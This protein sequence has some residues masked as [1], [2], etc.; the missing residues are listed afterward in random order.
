MAYHQSMARAGTEPTTK[1]Y[2]RILV[3]SPGGRIC[4]ENPY[5]HFG[6]FDVPCP[7][8]RSGTAADLIDGGV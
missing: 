8:I 2:I 5:R 1:P 4:D 6:G 3:A 7:E